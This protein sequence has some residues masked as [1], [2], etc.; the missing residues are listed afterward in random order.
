LKPSDKSEGR[1]KERKGLSLS[2]GGKKG[3]AH[4]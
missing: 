2:E 4:A 1:E 3:N